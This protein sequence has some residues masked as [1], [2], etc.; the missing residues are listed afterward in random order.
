MMK[1][2]IYD[3]RDRR[4]QTTSQFGMDMFGAFNLMCRLRKENEYV[5]MILVESDVDEF[6][7]MWIWRKVECGEIV[8]NS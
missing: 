6:H 2:P 4:F 7:L 5:N 8:R 1:F 3:K